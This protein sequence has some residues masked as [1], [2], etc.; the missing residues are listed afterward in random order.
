[1]YADVIGIFKKQTGTQ[2]DVHV[3]L[4]KIVRVSTVFNA[5]MA[6]KSLI[7]FAKVVFFHFIK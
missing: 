4:F 1:L 3:R 7:A 6:C 2:A 5:N